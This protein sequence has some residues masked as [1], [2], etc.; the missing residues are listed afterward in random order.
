MFPT[1]TAQTF[2]SRPEYHSIALESA[3][4]SEFVAPNSSLAHITFKKFSLFRACG[5]LTIGLHPNGF[6]RS[7][8]LG[9]IFN[10]IQQTLLSFPL[11][12]ALRSANGKT[13]REV[14]R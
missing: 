12:K 7:C 3:S 6:K 13:S 14:D 10:Q 8:W 11:E 9:M 4:I 5:M 2:R 1:F